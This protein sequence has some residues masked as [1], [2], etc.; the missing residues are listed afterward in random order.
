MPSCTTQSHSPDS[1]KHGEKKT[2]CVDN[3]FG[4]KPKRE[5][6]LYNYFK[7]FTLEEPKSLPN[8]FKKIPDTTGNFC[9]IIYQLGDIV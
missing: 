5:F 9:C 8:L 3:K 4:E 1:N 7:R 2:G 6:R